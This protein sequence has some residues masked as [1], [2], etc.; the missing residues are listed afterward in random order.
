MTVEGELYEVVD[1]VER[2]IRC[3]A[4]GHRCLIKDGGRG[5]CKVRYNE[6]G[7]LRVPHGYVG[8]LQLDPIEKKPFN[9][10][11][12]GISVISYGMLGCDFHCSYCFTPETPIATSQG[13]APIGELFLKGECVP[14]PDGAEVAFPQDLS[15][16]AG[17]GRFRQ[18]TKVF[19]HW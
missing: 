9:H 15:V 13:V 2:K 16:V 4:C 5:I 19:K 18:V 3:Y 12:P 7:K 6:D 11:S 17:S 10:V 1:E 8:A 14:Q